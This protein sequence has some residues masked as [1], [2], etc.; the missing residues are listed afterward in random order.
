MVA[1]VNGEAAR[2]PPSALC[3]AALVGE[4]VP[5]WV[6]AADE[7]DA[8]ELALSLP[9]MG[10]RSVDDG[11]AELSRARLLLRVGCPD[12]ALAI[13]S[14]QGVAVL[15]AE[16]GASWP[17]LLLAACRTAVGDDDAYR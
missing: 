6:A 8:F 9:A 13:L 7:M 17:Y 12:E 5:S 10:G 1:A 2:T 16:F 11:E 15:P 3:P 14:R 4:S